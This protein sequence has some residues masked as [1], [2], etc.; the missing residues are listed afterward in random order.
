MN[1]H[2]D[3]AIDKLI[4]EVE[5]KDK[6]VRGSA[7]AELDALRATVAEQARQLEQA[8]AIIERQYTGNYRSYTE[9]RDN[10]RAWLDA[11]AP[12]PQAQPAQRVTAEKENHA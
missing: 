6:R 3:G 5:R 12:A 4:E 11:N 8:R 2:Y 7:R 1:N 10:M 9:R